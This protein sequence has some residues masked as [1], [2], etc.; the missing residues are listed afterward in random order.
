MEAHSDRFGKA[1]AAG[2]LALIALGFGAF[3]DGLY[4]PAQQL[5]GAAL[6]ALLA[7]AVPGKVRLAPL[8]CA[9]LFLLLVGVAASLVSPA[10]AGVAAHGPAVAA[11]WV[12]ALLV[13]RA[14]SGRSWPERALARFWAAAATLLAFGGMVLISFTPPHHSGRLASFLGYP[15][16]VGVIGLL[17]LAGSLPD[18]AEGRPWAGALA[19]GSGLG[20]LLSGSRGV[21][22]AAILLA[23]YLVWAAPALLRAAL[24]R[25][26]PALALALAAALWAAPAVAS[27]QGA[28][29]GAILLL[30]LLTLYVVERFQRY[31]TV[32]IAA[33]AAWAGALLLA[34]GWGWLL[35]RATALPLTEGSSVERLTFLRDG[36][37]LFIQK[38]WGSG[39]RAWS[40]LHLQAASYG[41]Y[42]TEVHSALVDLALGFGWAGALAFAL[43][44][45]RLF[46]HL[47]RA[48]RW[49]PWRTVVLG[50]LAALALHS[51]V[52]WDLS[53]GLF[54]LPLWFGFGLLGPGEGASGRR[55]WPGGLTVALASLTLAATALVGAGDLFTELAHGA[56]RTGQPEA[57]VRHAEVA[58][59]VA[60]WNDLAHG[61]H[62]QALIQ[63]GRG[64]EGLA[65]LA[66]ARTL[67]PREPWY[68]ELEAEELARQGRALDAA[69]AWSDVV[70]LWPWEVTAYERALS[71][72]LVLMDRALAQGQRALARSLA[73]SGEAIINA[74]YQ[75]KARE[76]AGAPRQGMAVDTPTIERAHLRFQEVLAQ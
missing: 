57:A 44:I 29:L 60:P 73:E 41:Y 8:E 58:V 2:R 23:A 35:G 55:P 28:Q 42:S 47:R 26:V 63:V 17:G 14:V 4:G 20:L 7:L 25:A 69:A 56:I 48:R 45:A 5:A 31:G 43:L 65:S 32:R 75:Q 40:A 54:A 19:L 1:T 18:L 6:A 22:A 70:R 16:A 10:A 30:V 62:G 72:H 38:P 12:L 68:A 51:L 9:A 13:G 52:D 67:G 59:A 66:R 11:G 76:P 46:L 49:S 64:A 50:G 24:P 27:R 33:G 34:P 39:Y 36:F 61:Y 3:W 15:I 37:A 21:W 71:A 53:Y 74:L